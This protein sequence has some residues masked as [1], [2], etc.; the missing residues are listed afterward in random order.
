[1]I[2]LTVQWGLRLFRADSNPTTYR[3][4]VTSLSKSSPPVT[5]SRTMKI[6]VR[7]A[8]TSRSWTT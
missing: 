5:S 7:E 4:S 3:P 6:L 8:S 1:M 2:E